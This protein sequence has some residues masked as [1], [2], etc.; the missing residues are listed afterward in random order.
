M[1]CPDLVQLLSLDDFPF[2]PYSSPSFLSISLSSSHLCSCFSVDSHPFPAS[3]LVARD[4]IY[5]PFATKVPKHFDFPFLLFHG[6]FTL[7]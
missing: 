1:L 3:C 6:S 2:P 4:F 7:S 5:D